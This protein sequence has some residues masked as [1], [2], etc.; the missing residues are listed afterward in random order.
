[1][2]PFT[3]D[4]KDPTCFSRRIISVLNCNCK[5]LFPL[6]CPFFC[7]TSINQDESGQEI[8]LKSSRG[9]NERFPRTGQTQGCSDCCCCTDRRLSINRE[10]SATAKTRSKC[11]YTCR[12]NFEYWIDEWWSLVSD[13]Q[14]KEK[15]A[16]SNCQSHKL[17]FGCARLTMVL[18][19]MTDVDFLEIWFSSKLIS[20][21]HSS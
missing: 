17:H 3:E 6:P 15:R 1:M 13:S 12:F 5:S 11:N 4:P 10:T 16:S 19:M 8:P 21:Y 2:F 20:D 14:A 7:G 18:M 9:D